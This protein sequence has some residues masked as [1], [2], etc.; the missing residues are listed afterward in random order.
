MLYLTHN[1]VLCLGKGHLLGRGHIVS[2][3]GFFQMCTI[4]SPCK[5]AGELKALFSGI[6]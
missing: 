4:L 3:V 5:T 2:G 1:S 6:K